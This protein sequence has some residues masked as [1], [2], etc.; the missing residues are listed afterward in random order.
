LSLLKEL[1][2]SNNHNIVIA[3]FER[4]KFAQDDEC[5]QAYV[6]ALVRA[7]Q[8]DKILPKIMQ[9]LEQT[10]TEGGNAY[11]NKNL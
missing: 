11:I 6:T 3:R 7:G 8:T 5:F 4:G 9:K 10:G 1:L 2:K